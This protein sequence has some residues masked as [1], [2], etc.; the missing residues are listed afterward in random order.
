MEKVVLDNGLVGI[1]KF[2]FF[3]EHMKRQDSELVKYIFDNTDVEDS[4]IVTL[5]SDSNEQFNNT[6]GQ[7]HVR[8]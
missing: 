2:F 1:F 3:K 6:N 7:L 4:D 8:S 5:P